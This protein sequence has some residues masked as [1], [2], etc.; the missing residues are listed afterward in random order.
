MPRLFRVGF[1]RLCD[2]DFTCGDGDGNGD[3]GGDD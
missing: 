1:V 3:R 2:G